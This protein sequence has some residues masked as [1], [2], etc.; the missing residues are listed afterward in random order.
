MNQLP[1]AVPTDEPVVAWVTW[2]DLVAP[3]GVTLLSP[4]DG[5]LTPELLDHITFY[6]PTYLGGRAALEPASRMPRLRVLQLPNAGYDNAVEFLR[7]GVTLCNARGVHDESTAE[8]AVGLALANRRGFATFTRNQLH[9][10][11]QH[12]Q[13][14]SL[15]DSRIAV[16]GH[17]SIGRT[18]HRMLG[19]FDVT[20]VLFSRSGRD[21]AQPV[22][23]L[24]ELI[25]SFDVVILV[26]PLT[27]ETTGMFG[28]ELLGRMKDGALLVNVARGG[29]VDTPALLA[30]LTAG[31]LAAALDVTDPEPLPGDHPLWHAP[32]CLITPHVGGDTTAF[33]PRER[34]NPDPAGAPVPGR[35]A[36]ER[37]HGGILRCALTRTTTY[38]T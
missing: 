38:G 33:E 12:E 14:P 5:P 27:A 3:P 36:G 18:V 10:T 20:I 28:A 29:V 2:P 16:V 25:G 9:G 6:A 11:W 23:R 4:A 22:E 24:P 13:R 17:G 30:E 31:R 8:L 26:L 32:N 35:S 7:P 37:R 19:G 15:T 34:P 21:G 1:S